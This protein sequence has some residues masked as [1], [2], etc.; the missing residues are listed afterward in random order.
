MIG[1]SF[2][3]E[4][5]SSIFH[6]TVSCHETQEQCIQ[7]TN[8]NRRSRRLVYGRQSYGEHLMTLFI[9]ELRK[10]SLW[11]RRLHKNGLDLSQ[12]IIHA[13]VC[14][15]HMTQN[16]YLISIKKYLKLNPILLRY[17]KKNILRREPG[18]FDDN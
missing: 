6:R 18:T 7:N 2:I 4:L 5:P 11:L 10:V 8:H 12:K 13:C 3:N 16:R 17:F 1:D 14:S 9:E 15:L